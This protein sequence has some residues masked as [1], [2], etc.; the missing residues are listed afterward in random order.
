MIYYWDIENLKQ[1][2]EVWIQITSEVCGQTLTTQKVVC[3]CVCV[4]VCN[5]LGLCPYR[6]IFLGA[7]SY[8]FINKEMYPKWQAGLEHRGFQANE[9]SLME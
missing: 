8:V 4:C 5:T 2:W 1:S 3:I 6:F 7:N 9:K